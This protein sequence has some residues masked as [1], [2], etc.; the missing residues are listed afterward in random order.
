MMVKTSIKMRK[1]AWEPQSPKFNL[2]ASPIGEVA[3]TFH[4]E[5]L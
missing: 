1:T 5:S 2:S 3:Y 4:D